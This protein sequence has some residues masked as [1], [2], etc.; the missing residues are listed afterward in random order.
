MQ[1][2]LLTDSSFSICKVDAILG[3]DFLTDSTANA[4]VCN[5]ISFELC[6]AVSNGIG[7]SENWIYAKIKVL[8]RAVFYL[9]ANT[10]ISLVTGIEVCKIRLFFKN[11]VN[12]SFLF[13]FI[14]R[15]SLCRKPYHLLESRVDKYLHTSVCKKLLCNIFSSCGEKIKGI[16]VIMHCTD[17]TYLRIAVF[18][19]G[20]DIQS[21]CS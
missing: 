16:L 1:A 6:I 19:N 12:G 15:V 18:V 21:L 5:L 17:A 7:F 20:S 8:Y 10:D 2:I 14:Y 9:K 13:F 3:T 4:L 11:G